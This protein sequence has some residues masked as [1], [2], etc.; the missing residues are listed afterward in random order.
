MEHTRKKSN[1]IMRHM[2]LL[3]LLVVAA[4]ALVLGTFSPELWAHG[5]KH[6]EE[7]KDATI[8]VETNATAGDAGFQ[9]FLDGEGWRHVSVYDPKGRQ[10]FNVKTN[11]GVKKIGGG[12]E[13]FVETAEPEFETPEEL[14]ELLDLLQPGTYK[15]YGGTVEGKWLFGEA[16]LTHVIPAGPNVT[17]ATPD[18][19]GECEA[20]PIDH[21]EI[22]WEPVTTTIFGSDDIEI[23]GYQVI[24]EDEEGNHTF[25]V[26]L[27]AG[28]RSITIPEEFLEPG[29]VYLFEVLAIEES[30]NQTITESCFVV[31]E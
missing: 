27:P 20:L 2:F 21:A 4:F 17:P 7:L 6:K 19:E 31:E 15:F 25:D 13:L 30:G 16:E 23:V 3:P 29:A 10:I 9:I 24:V 8:I 14:Q 28:T 5:K 11:G 18:D 26:T 22:S 12:T 1:G